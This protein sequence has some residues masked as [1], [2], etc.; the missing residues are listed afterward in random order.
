VCHKLFERPLVQYDLHGPVVAAVRQMM[1]MLC[2]NGR[3]KEAATLYVQLLE[4]EPKF[5]GG[6]ASC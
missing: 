5:F 2:G 6:R 3:K 4:V 1:L